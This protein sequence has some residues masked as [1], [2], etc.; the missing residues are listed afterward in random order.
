MVIKTALGGELGKA[1]T[2]ALRLQ[3]RVSSRYFAHYSCS[4]G[5]PNTE[6][7]TDLLKMLSPDYLHRLR[8]ELLNYQ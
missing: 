6:I 5:T 7:L 1:E 4:P 2:S 8:A 3:L